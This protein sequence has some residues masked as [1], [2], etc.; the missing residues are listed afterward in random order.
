MESLTRAT[1]ILSLYLQIAQVISLMFAP[2]IGSV[3]TLKCPTGQ[4]ILA[5]LNQ[6]L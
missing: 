2:L 5:Y 1:N 6:C 4:T 3:A